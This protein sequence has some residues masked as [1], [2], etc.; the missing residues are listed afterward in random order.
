MTLTSKY[1]PDAAPATPVNPLQH[2]YDVC[3]QVSVEAFAVGGLGDWFTRK[4][5]TIT[6]AI[7]EAFRY[8][9]TS[10][11]TKPEVIAT[12][13]L[14]QMLSTIQYSEM[15]DY[16]MHIPVGLRTGML[17]YTKLLDGTV[18]EL[19]SGL[20]DNV[21]LPAQK[22]FGH[23]LSNPSDVNERRDF[24]HGASYSAER[25][26]EVKGLMGGFL[27]PG[28]RSST[29]DY[30]DVFSSNTE[31][32]NS[33]EHLNSANTA[34]WANAN[35]AQLDKQ[36][37]IL[38]KIATSLFDQLANGAGAKA[39]PQFTKML[40]DELRLVAQWVEWYAV[41]VTQIVDATTAMKHNELLIM[42]IK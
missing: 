13:E 19:L 12:R 26:E 28:N 20:L 8:V 27:Q 25:L 5:A 14:R 32:L 33:C 36:V 30:G 34:R 9:T 21:I 16:S 42:N 22:R 29:R 23:Y 24:A 15:M 17:D 31:F 38:V 35:P 37:Q 41:A 6:H 7:S 18:K 10:D 4:G 3:D 2:L 11:F 40:G 1:L 39:T